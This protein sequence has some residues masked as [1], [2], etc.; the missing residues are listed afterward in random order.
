MPRRYLLG[1]ISG[2][3]LPLIQKESKLLNTKKTAQIVDR[4]NRKNIQV[5]VI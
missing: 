3:K 4:N 1:A 5:F 2:L